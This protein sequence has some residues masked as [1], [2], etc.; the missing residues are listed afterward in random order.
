MKT[1]GNISR[2]TSK[3]K[4]IKSIEFPYEFQIYFTPELFQVAMAV[5]LFV[6]WNQLDDPSVICTKFNGNGTLVAGIY[7][8]R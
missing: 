2:S 6:I 3:Q 7:S 4:Q 8:G 5:M 1:C